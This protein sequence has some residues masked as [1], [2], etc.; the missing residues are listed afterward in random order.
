[1]SNL[2]AYC[3][4]SCFLPSSPP[5]VL[6]PLS[7]PPFSPPFPR[8]PFPPTYRRVSFLTPVV[9]APDFSVSFSSFSELVP[10]PLV[11]EHG[12]GPETHDSIVFLEFV[13]S[14]LLPSFFSLRAS[15][16]NLFALFFH[17]LPY[18]ASGL[19][20]LH[21]PCFFHFGQPLSF[22][23]PLLTSKLEESSPTL[24]ATIMPVASD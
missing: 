13:K 21:F 20:R 19:F 14:P 22:S 6:T 4:F 2:C 5:T 17:S 8:D 24:P 15:T 7:F 1:M 18:F 23:F 10:R 16:W 9:D 11:C 12:A 3:S